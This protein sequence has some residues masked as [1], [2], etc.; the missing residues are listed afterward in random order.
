[1][2]LFQNVWL[3]VPIPSPAA[4]HPVTLPDII[5]MYAAMFRARVN[6]NN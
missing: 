1:M 5:P 2:I 4:H 6:P 3:G